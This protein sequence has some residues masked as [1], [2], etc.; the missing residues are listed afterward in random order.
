MMYS[1]R[2]L[3]SDSQFEVFDS[4]SQFEAQLWQQVLYQDRRPWMAYW[5]MIDTPTRS[6]GWMPIAWLVGW[7]VDRGWPIS[8]Q[9]VMA[10]PRSRPD[11]SRHMDSMPSQCEPAHAPALASH[12]GVDATVAKVFCSEHGSMVQ[13]C[14]RFRWYFLVGKEL[15][16]IQ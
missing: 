8:E 1:I 9:H 12:A 10:I 11:S 5:L 16:L 13:I 6:I 2:S 7:L 3:R 15:P 4:D 14:F